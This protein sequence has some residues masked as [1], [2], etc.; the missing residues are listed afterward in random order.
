MLV[1][2]HPPAPLE[3]CVFGD[4]QAPSL[5]PGERQVQRIDLHTEPIEIGRK[6]TQP[7]TCAVEDIL[8]SATR[9]I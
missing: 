9:T 5:S 4:F 8:L 3:A 7:V 2:V 6:Y 1:G